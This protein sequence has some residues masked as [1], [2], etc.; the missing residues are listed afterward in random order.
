MIRREDYMKKFVLLSIALSMFGSVMTPVINAQDDSSD[1][2]EA[3]SSESS[4]EV[5]ESSSEVE[6]SSSIEEEA[7]ENGLRVL[8]YE[9]AVEYANN[10]PERVATFQSIFDAAVKTPELGMSLTQAQYDAIPTDAAYNVLVHHLMTI[11][12]GGD[13]STTIRFLFEVYPELAYITE[14]SED[15]AEEDSSEESKTE[16]D[17]EGDETEDESGD[18]LELLK[19]QTFEF[20]QGSYEVEHVFVLRPNEASNESAEDYLLGVTYDFT[21]LTEEAARDIEADW[22]DNVNVAQLVD[23]Q[24]VVLEVRDDASSDEGESQVEVLIEENET[25]TQTVYY[26]LENTEDLAT[27]SVN[28]ETFE[29][30]IEKL[31]KL[32]PQSA[33]YV[34]DNAMQAFIFDFQTLYAASIDPVDMEYFTES[35]VDTLSDEAKELYDLL[36]EKF[37]GAEWTL[38]ELKVDYELDEEDESVLVSQAEDEDDSDNAQE[39]E[40]GSLYGED[41]WAM[42]MFD[43]VRYWLVDG[44]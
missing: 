8:T 12:T 21:N 28:G 15:E 14:S 39:K 6:E 41:D 1:D 19:E 36:Q 44:E 11:P 10:H 24:E 16:S 2:L 3:T 43:D 18:D 31:L 5:V 9:E 26:E 30:S 20:G 37:E 33:L 4:A 42:F 17:A 7:P 23:D 22:M 29:L 13:P 34:S 25:V 35:R 27:L 40:I 38:Y 32:P